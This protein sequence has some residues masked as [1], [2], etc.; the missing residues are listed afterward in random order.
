[1][2]EIDTIVRCGTIRSFCGT[3]CAKKGDKVFILHCLRPKNDELFLMFPLVSEIRIEGC[4]WHGIA[5]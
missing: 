5:T 3:W 1:M 2:V 4:I